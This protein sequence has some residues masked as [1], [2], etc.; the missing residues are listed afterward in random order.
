MAVV[1]M[2][3]AE[4]VKDIIAVLAKV[5]Q[6]IIRDDLGCSAGV[7]VEKCWTVKSMNCLTNLAFLPRFFSQWASH[8]RLLSSK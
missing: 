6:G 4:V 5:R 7:S 8:T 1:H 2:S 3:E